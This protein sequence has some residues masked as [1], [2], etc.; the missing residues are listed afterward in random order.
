MGQYV[1]RYYLQAYDVKI[2]CFLIFILSRQRYLKAAISTDIIKDVPE[3][4]I[5]RVLGDRLHL[6]HALPWTV[7]L[8]STSAADE[9]K[10]NFG[11]Q[12]MLQWKVGLPEDGEPAARLRPAAGEHLR[13]HGPRHHHPARQG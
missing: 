8:N 10:F 11:Y 9:Q 3:N 6:T 13:D 2:L 5:L 4:S 7:I 12:D 1:F